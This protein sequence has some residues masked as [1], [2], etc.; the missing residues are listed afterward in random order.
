M[1]APIVIGGYIALE[2]LLLW[3]GVGTAAVATGAVIVDNMN[4]A[5]KAAGSSQSGTSSYADACSSC[6]PAPECDKKANEIEK[7]RN[8][9]K[10]RDSEMYEDQHD[11]FGRYY[12]ESTP[13]PQYGSWEGHL[14]QFQQKQ[15][16]LRRLLGEYD[17]MGCP[18]GNI[19]SDAYRWGTQQPYL[20]KFKG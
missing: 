3:L 4:E 14:R 11:L 2:K 8:E 16:R 12:S 15:Q 17:T 5:N 18:K 6:Q 20:P 7:T 9:L 10:K 1:G 13:H 19:P